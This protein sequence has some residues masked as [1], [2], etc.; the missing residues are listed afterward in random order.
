MSTFSFQ[1][2]TGAQAAAFSAAADSLNFGAG[3]ANQVTVAYQSAPE[4]VA[5]SF[6][7]QSMTFG[8]GVYGALSLKFDNGGM[9]FVGGT[10]ADSAIGTA[11]SDA[12]FGGPGGD[13]LTGGDGA[14]VL[15]G[16][17]GADSLVGGTGNDSIYGGQ[18]NDAIVLGTGAAESNFTNGNK[19]DDT[20]SAS[21]GADVVLG[22]QGDDQIT[23]GTGGDVLD[24]NLGNDTIVGGP[25]ADT[26]TGE[27]G[28]DVM[29]GGGGADL[30]VFAAGSSDVS[31][32]LAD[33]I[34]D[35]AP[36]DHIGLP[37]HGGYAEAMNP[38]AGM[39]PTGGYDPYG[40][41]TP[42]PPT[43][44]E[45]TSAT[46][47]ANMAMAG[48]HTLQIVAVQD[49]ADVTVF[50]DTNGDHVVDLAVVLLNATL[51]QIDATNFV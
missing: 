46:N 14:N 42:P 36:G 15:Q 17:Q 39:P 13:T 8:P 50:V 37:V 6:N 7:G 9:V 21:N 3:E 40:G 5:I 12:M 4:Q 32:A 22:G 18:D 19:G 34:R 44:D 29:T 28:Y 23:G 1:T 48:D 45:F 26:I 11:A 31:N 38:S 24:G 20:I 49:S 27:G 47:T 41:Y 2:I 25:G 51:A 30:F 43:S 16:N 35:W 10:G 33:R